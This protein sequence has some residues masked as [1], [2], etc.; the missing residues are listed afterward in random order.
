MLYRG[1]I[2]DRQEVAWRK[3]REVFDEAEQRYATLSLFLNDREVP[4]KAID[5]LQVKLAEMESRRPC[6]PRGEVFLNFSPGD[7]PCE[8]SF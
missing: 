4:A 3:T 2:D 5:S 7:S 1:E 8:R 6:V